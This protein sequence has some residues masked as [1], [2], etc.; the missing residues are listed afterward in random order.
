MAK[1]FGFFG[2]SLQIFEIFDVYLW[3]FAVLVVFVCSQLLLFG[4]SQLEV[5]VASTQHH[6][7]ERDTDQHNEMS[8]LVGWYKTKVVFSPLLHLLFNFLF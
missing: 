5:F 1:S 7:K 4:F 3:M 6:Q 2:W 8:P